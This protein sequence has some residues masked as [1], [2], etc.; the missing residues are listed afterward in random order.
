[1]AYDRL[2]RRS[3]TNY[4]QDDP[5]DFES[6]SIPNPRLPV[7]VKK[8]EKIRDECAH[9]FPCNYTFLV[10]FEPL[11]KTI[12]KRVPHRVPEHKIHIY[13]WGGGH[14]HNSDRPTPFE[15]SSNQSVMY[16]PCGYKRPGGRVISKKST[17]SGL[18]SG[19]ERGV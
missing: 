14:P 10:G 3:V 7:P 13:L 6:K 18:Q 16:K 15:N 1:M 8:R 4:C 19:K 17:L 11:R 2:S 9:F 12:W 5:L